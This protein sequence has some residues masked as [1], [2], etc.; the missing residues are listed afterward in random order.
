MRSRLLVRVRLH[1]VVHG[2]LAIDGEP[3]AI[4]VV[5]RSNCMVLLNHDIVRLYMM[6]DLLRTATF[7]AGLGLVF[8]SVFE[9]LKAIANLGFVE[10][11]RVIRWLCGTS[12]RLLTW[13]SG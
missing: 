5:C 3:F 6:G 4:L 8:V 12:Y 10:A 9:Q 11:V 7:A 2:L 13:T 1:S